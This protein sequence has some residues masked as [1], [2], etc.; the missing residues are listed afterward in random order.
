MRPDPER[1][2]Q[3]HPHRGRGGVANIFQ[4]SAGTCCWNGLVVGWR[5]QGAV[6][7]WLN[8]QQYTQLDMQNVCVYYHGCNGA[9]CSEIM[10]LQ[11]A[12]K[13]QITSWPTGSVA[14]LRGGNYMT[15]T[16]HCQTHHWGVDE[17]G[18]WS[19]GVSAWP[20]SRPTCRLQPAEPGSSSWPARGSGRSAG[21]GSGRSSESAGCFPRPS[22][23]PP[24]LP[25]DSHWDAKGRRRLHIKWMLYFQWQRVHEPNNLKEAGALCQTSRRTSRCGSN[26]EQEANSD[27]VRANHNQTHV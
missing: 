27:N 13:A 7:Q 22:A 12:P 6:S 8:D 1:H 2:I 11:P 18:R 23:A 9:T 26:F 21:W 3:P 19:L 4:L 17:R 10:S 16:R 20:G 25:P 15:R 14:L 24:D 5:R